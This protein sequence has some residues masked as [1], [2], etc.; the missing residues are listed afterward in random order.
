MSGFVETVVRFALAPARFVIDRVRMQSAGPL[1]ELGDGEGRIIESG[2]RKLAAYRDEVG[3]VHAVAP[4]CTHLRCVVEFNDAERRWDCP[5][6][7]SRFGIDGEVLKGP[8]RR[9]LERV[10]ID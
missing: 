8:A 2:G 9:P 5:C 3:V 10:A 6:H 4:I 7:G 1:D